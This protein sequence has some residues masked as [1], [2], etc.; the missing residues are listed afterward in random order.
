MKTLLI[1]NGSKHTLKL[2]SLLNGH[3]VRIIPNKFIKLKDA[4]DFDVI[5]LSG[6]KINSVIGNKELYENEVGI[7]KNINKPIIGICLGFELIA[8][9]FGTML[10]KLDERIQGII[11]IKII[12]KDKIVNDLENVYAYES[13]RWIVKKLSE[14]LVGLAESKYGY[15]IIKHKNKQIYGCQFHPEI[16]TNKTNGHKVFQNFL[17]LVN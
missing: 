10:Q 3:Y 17:R 13:H 14:N 6:G 4:D 7:I 8:H 9:S 1:D 15:E 5:I 12:K 16:I 11:S 2:K